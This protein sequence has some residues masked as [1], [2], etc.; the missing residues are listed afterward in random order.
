MHYRVRDLGLQ[1]T[2][3]ADAAGHFVVA[4]MPEDADVEVWAEGNATGAWGA[5]V[6]T[7]GNDQLALVYTPRRRR[8]DVELTS[9]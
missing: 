5:Q 1:G 8:T 6:A 2:E 3:K 9:S 7:P 4:G